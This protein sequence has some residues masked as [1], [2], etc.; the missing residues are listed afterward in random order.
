LVHCFFCFVFVYVVYIH[1]AA[2]WFEPLDCCFNDE[3]LTVRHS[4]ALAENEIDQ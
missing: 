2:V 3:N 4:L 1:S